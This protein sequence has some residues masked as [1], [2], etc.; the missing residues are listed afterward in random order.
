MF[1]KIILLL[2]HVKNDIA[3]VTRNK[4]KKAYF[5]MVS[6]ILLNIVKYC[7]IGFLV[8]QTVFG[9]KNILIYQQF[10]G[11][12]FK[13]VCNSYAVESSFVFFNSLKA[14]SLEISI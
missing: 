1:V 14:K 13:K 8:H 10:K 4:Y 3:D 11:L 12:F 5:P 7:K 9:Y 6:Q 2:N